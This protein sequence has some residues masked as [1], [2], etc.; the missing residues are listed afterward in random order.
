MAAQQLLT[1]VNNNLTRNMRSELKFNFSSHILYLFSL[2]PT[3][4]P[5]EIEEDDQTRIFPCI[6]RIATQLAWRLAGWPACLLCSAGLAVSAVCLLA[7][8]HVLGITAWVSRLL[9][10]SVLPFRNSTLSL[11]SSVIHQDFILLNDTR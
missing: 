10:V 1:L 3:L 2:L 11:L 6:S 7:S 4:S 9:S 5:H 8:P